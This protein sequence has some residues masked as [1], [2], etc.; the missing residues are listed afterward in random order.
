M[1][2]VG[3]LISPIATDISPILEPR[4][5][6]LEHRMLDGVPV[7]IKLQISFGYVR[8]AH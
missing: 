8:R 6:V 3:Q 7:F 5:E 4:E 1:L 2:G